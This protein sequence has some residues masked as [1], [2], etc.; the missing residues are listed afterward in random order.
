[1]KVAILGAGGA[2]GARIVESFQLGEGPSL[3]AIAAAAADLG[4][5]ARFPIDLRVVD[6]LD[7]AALA[8]SFSGCSA[9]VH[10]LSLDVSDLKRGALAFCRAGAQAGVRRLIYV[11]TAEVYGLAP[12][13]GTGENSRLHVRHASPRINAL[14]AADRQFATESRRLGLTG[15]VLRPAAIYGPR[16]DWLVEVVGELQRNRAWLANQGEGICNCVYVDQVVAAVRLVLKIK[17]IADSAFIVTDEETITWGDF[18]RAVAQEFELPEVIH[19]DP[20]PSPPSLAAETIARQRCTWKLSSAPATKD[21]GLGPATTFAEGMRRSA[22]WWRFAQ[23][24]FAA[25]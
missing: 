4:A 20:H 10:A 1:M 2:L 18:Y 9:A 22:A 14:V 17:K 7:P 19:Y 12:P 23:G 24:N 6:P 16:S 8:R 13:V 11:S 21:L 3:T 5:A 15:I 25:A